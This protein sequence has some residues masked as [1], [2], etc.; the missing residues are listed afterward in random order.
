MSEPLPIEKS[1]RTVLRAIQ[2][3]DYISKKRTSCSI[4]ELSKNLQI[5][6]TSVFDIVHTLKQEGM[7]IFD[8]QTKSFSLGMKLYQLGMAYLDSMDL[9]SLILPYLKNLSEKYDETAYF[10]IPNNST[11]LYI[12]KIEGRSP[13]RTTCIIGDTNDMYSTGLG[14]AM[15][16]AM[17]IKEIIQMYSNLPFKAKTKNTVQNIGELLTELETIRKRGYSTDN[18]EDNY[19]IF[20]ISAPILNSNNSVAGAISISMFKT[21]ATLEKADLIS[22][23]VCSTAFEI[24]RKLGFRKNTLFLN[25]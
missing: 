10:A 25:D 24:S 21:E 7:L 2:I 22:K 12:D 15:L 19:G 8:E 4:L 1:N 11:I 16:A 9:H 18:E 14:K 3:M 17:P 6:K 23:D 5:P 13:L 20:C